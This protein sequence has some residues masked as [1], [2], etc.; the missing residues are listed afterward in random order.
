M[1]ATDPTPLTRDNRGSATTIAVAVWACTLPFVFL[2]IVPWLGL[3]A[4]VTTALALLVGISL[5][6]WVLCA[7]T[8]PLEGPSGRN[9]R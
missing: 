8:Q 1:A 9:T 4:A 6:C 5:V 3:R 7:A 2:L